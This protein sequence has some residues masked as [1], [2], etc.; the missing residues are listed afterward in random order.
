MLDAGIIVLSHTPWSAKAIVFFCENKTK[1][2][3]VI[4]YSQTINWFTLLNA[5]SLPRVDD[6]IEKIA[7]TA[8]IVLWTLKVPTVKLL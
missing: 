1:M 3:M 8:Y 7:K 4:D 6:V 2:L 5:Y